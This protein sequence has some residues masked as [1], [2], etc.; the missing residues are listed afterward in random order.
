MLPY[1]YA[2]C[3]RYFPVNIIMSIG[4]KRTTIIP[5]HSFKV[6]LFCDSNL[7]LKMKNICG[8]LPR[9]KILVDV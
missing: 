6:A 5:D 9:A 8:Y 4:A 7:L 1:G 3:E 2:S